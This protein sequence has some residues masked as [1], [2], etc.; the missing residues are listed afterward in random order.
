MGQNMC[1]M[2]NVEDKKGIAL[3]REVGMEE[4]NAPLVAAYLKNGGDPDL[5]VEYELMPESPIRRMKPRLIKMVCQGDKDNTFQ[6]LAMVLKAGA[7]IVP[8]VPVLID[9]K[10]GDDATPMD[11]VCRQEIL[12]VT[13]Y[14]LLCCAAPTSIIQDPTKLMRT[15]GGTIS[16]YG[17]TKQPE[18]YKPVYEAVAS[19]TREQK[20]LI[21]GA[22]TN[23]AGLGDV[24]EFSGLDKKLLARISHGKMAD[25]F[26]DSELGQKKRPEEFCTIDDAVAFVKA[27]AGQGS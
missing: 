13:G 6:A 20:Q 27:A 8:D 17:P 18:I 25:P 4:D 9:G 24:A 5:C 19:L 23:A 14:M 15:N 21:L 3:L 26:Y 22:M 2:V 11:D 16:P 7:S 12:R 10:K 1:G